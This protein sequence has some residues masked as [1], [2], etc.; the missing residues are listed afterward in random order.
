MERHKGIPPVVGVA[1]PWSAYDVVLSN[2]QLA[3]V[4]KL[5][6]VLTGS[7]DPVLDTPLGYFLH[8]FLGLPLR[9]PLANLLK[10]LQK[11]L[12]LITVHRPPTQNFKPQPSEQSIITCPHPTTLRPTNAQ[13]TT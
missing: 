2:L 6:M 5:V 1:P 10:P 9:P 3:D 8:T 7:L 11:I 13:A 4:T 12:L